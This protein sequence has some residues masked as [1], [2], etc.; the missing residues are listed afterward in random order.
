[1]HAS[2]LPVVFLM[3]PTATG[4]TEL[5][6]ALARELPCEIISVD[7]AMIYRGM[8]V[9]TA[10]PSPQILEAVPHHLVDILDPAQRYSAARFREDALGLVEA[11]HARGRLPLLVGG[12]ML[13]FRALEF[14]LDPLPQADPAVRGEIEALAA[15]AGWT[16]VHRELARLDPAAAAR[17]HPNDPQR[18]QRA[19]E[20]C[21]VSG[22]PLSAQ[23]GGAPQPE[24]PYRVLRLALMPGD[25]GPLRARIARRFEA[26]LAQGLVEEVR[27]LQ[28]RGDLTPAL[29]AIRAVGYRQVWAYLE[30]ELD[31]DT[32]VTKAVTAT[33]QLAKRQMTWLRRYP[34][35]VSLEPEGLD[36]GS[37]LAW[38]RRHTDP[39]APGGLC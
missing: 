23:H 37:V 17:I 8:D 35:V 3:G 19:L 4:K 31:H 15:R 22:R 34:G 5:A 18:L 9:G 30:G 25:R 21:R 38:V 24:L 27:A 33:R 39:M 2:P 11:I 29:P 26:M 12:T 13:Y 16:A 32:M 20:V 6:L 10:K 14:G 7:S 36:P 28:R 1:M